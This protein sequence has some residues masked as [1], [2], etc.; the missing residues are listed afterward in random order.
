MRSRR[1]PGGNRHSGARAAAAGR[2]LELA[3]RRVHG[4]RGPRALVATA[5]EGAVDAQVVHPVYDPLDGDVPGVYSVA[6]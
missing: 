3:L 4:H 1:S 2:E 6:S 5:R